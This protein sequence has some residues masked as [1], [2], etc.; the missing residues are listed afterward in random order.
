MKG[1]LTKR[2][3]NSW[4]IRVDLGRKPNGKR[5]QV[6]KSVKGT[7]KDAEAVLNEML[8]SYNTGTYVEPSKMT[9]EEYL[10]YWLDQISDS[11]QH[12]THERYESICDLY[13]NP[14]MGELKLADLRA[15]HINSLY[16]ELQTTGRPDVGLKLSAR[17][18]LHTHRVLSNALNKCVKWSMLV[19][20]PCLAAETPKPAKSKRPT[21]T[22]DETMEVLKKASS[23]RLSLPILLAVTTGL[24]R[25]EVLGLRWSDI[26]LERE[27]LTVR[28][29]VS[30]TVKYGIEYKSPKSDSSIRT[31]PLPRLTLDAL[32]AYMA[33]T[34]KLYLQLGR[35]LDKSKP[36]LSGL[37][38]FDKPSLLTASYKSFIKRNLFKPVSFHDLRHTH[39]TLLLEQNVHPKVVSDRLGHSTIALTMDTYSHVMPSIQKAASEMVDSIFETKM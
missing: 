3:K 9:I 34:A 30:E 16:K 12:R 31:I 32:K 29:S 24:R 39:A 36:I 38:G 33:E 22:A 17:T 28:Q 37:G 2:S 1:T 35:S 19:V 15:T 23:S 8:H 20:N 18:V 11:V 5:N 26:D 27:Q 7:K 14:I 6:S 4:T 10:T 13:I 21:F 25:G